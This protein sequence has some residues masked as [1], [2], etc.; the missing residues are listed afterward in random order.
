[1]K[2]FLR[3]LLEILFVSYFLFLWFLFFMQKSMLYIP[4]VTEFSK[5]IL[6]SKEEQK[7]YNQTRFY[8]KQLD[9]DKVIIFFHW[10]TWRAC[11]R[12]YIKTLFDKI[13]YSYIFVEYKWYADNLKTKPWKEEI[14]NDIKNTELY[15]K[16]K[17]YKNIYVVWEGF[18]TWPASYFTSKNKVEK[19]LLISS[20]SE[21]Y[22]V[23]SYKYKIFPLK[24]LYTQN[25]NNVESL[26]DYK[27]DLLFIHWSLD[28]D[29]PLELWEILFDSL[30]NDKKE[31]L[32]INKWDYNNLFDFSWV[33]DKIEE[34]F[35]K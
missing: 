5:C 32:T 17:D 3:I 27:N 8:E 9:K 28:K 19:L 35:R 2:K 34:F 16:T 1:M 21:L 7:V 30:E 24:Y 11:D 25:F 22:K 15:L 13:W 26:K 14:L 12:W 6:F 23:V 4:D 31:F 20:F 18:W 10:N 29:F 33:L